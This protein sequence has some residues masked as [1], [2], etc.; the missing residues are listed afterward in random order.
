MGGRE[1]PFVICLGGGRIAVVAES[2]LWLQPVLLCS[3]TLLLPQVGEGVPATAPLPASLLP[4]GGSGFLL[5]LISGLL[6]VMVGLLSSSTTC[7]ANNPPMNL[8]LFPRLK[9]ASVFLI[10]PSWIARQWNQ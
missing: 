5:W 7:V 1:S 8:P 9:A 10:G 6:T 4:K 2:P 3:T